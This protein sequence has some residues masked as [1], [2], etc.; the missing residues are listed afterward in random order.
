MT[1]E[2]GTTLGRY[3]ILTFAAESGGIERSEPIN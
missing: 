1:L 3:Q 2:P